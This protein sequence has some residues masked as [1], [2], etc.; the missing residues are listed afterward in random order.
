MRDMVRSD[1]VEGPIGKRRPHRIDIVRFTERGLA[2]PE[3]S[4]GTIELRTREVQVERAGLAE[5][6]GASLAL[7]NSLEGLPRAEMDEIDRRLRRRCE[8]DRLGDGLHL[9]LDRSALW[10]VL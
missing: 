4:I 8:I 9:G 7:A 2:D 6:A 1:R 5:H 10:E 3:R